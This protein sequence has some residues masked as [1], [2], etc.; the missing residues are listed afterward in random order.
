MVQA[1][2]NASFKGIE[3]QDDADQ[4]DR[5]PPLPPEKF[6]LAVTVSIRNLN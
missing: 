3:T 1:R 5:I 4:Y 2:P 6:T